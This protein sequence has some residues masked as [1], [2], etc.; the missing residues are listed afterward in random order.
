[1]KLCLYWYSATGNTLN[2]ARAARDWWRSHGVE[3]T[4]FD[5][6]NAAR[7]PVPAPA[8]F[9]KVVFAF[10]T[11]VFRAPEAARVFAQ[12]LPAS[13]RPVEAWLMITSGGMGA[14]TDSD[15]SGLIAKKN[16]V[17]R[18]AVELRCEDSYIPFRKYF[19]FM[20]KH[21]LPNDATREAAQ[22]FA[23]AVVGVEKTAYPPWR[24][25]A[26]S[27]FDRIGK[28]APREA[29]RQLLGPR[30]LDQELCTGCGLCSRL[31][32]VGAIHLIDEKPTVKE[33]LCVGC[34]ACFN[35]CGSKAWRLKR[36]SYRYHY[37]CPDEAVWNGL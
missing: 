23:A 31:C 34:L 33:N 6:L 29:A 9:D 11:M 36:F 12:N 14:K 13:E 21:G 18:G 19:G 10:P 17:T 24:G 8:D 3:L 1:M 26:R 20:G 15:F 27:F 16:I 35:N 7:L 28:N 25:I 32:P 22:K 37:R 2:V 4:G 5:M 30:R